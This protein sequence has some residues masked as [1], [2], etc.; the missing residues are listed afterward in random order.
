MVFEI[1]LESGKLVLVILE[2]MKVIDVWVFRMILFSILNFD[3]SFLIE[4][5]LKLIFFII[6]IGFV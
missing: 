5:E 3:I 6:V 4:I 1:V 2:D